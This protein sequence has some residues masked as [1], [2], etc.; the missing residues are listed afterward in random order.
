MPKN[1]PQGYLKRNFQRKIGPKKTPPGQT[2]MPPGIS[3]KI[4]GGGQVPPG[5]RERM[6][7]LMTTTPQRKIPRAQMYARKMNQMKGREN[8]PGQSFSFGAPSYRRKL[9]RNTPRARNFQ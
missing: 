6:H 2:R 7:N 1:N 4:L 5:L 8:N 3:Q 9:N